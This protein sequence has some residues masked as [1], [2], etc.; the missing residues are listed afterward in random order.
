MNWV[1]MSLHRGYKRP[2]GSVGATYRMDVLCAACID[3]N[4][5]IDTLRGRYRLEIA[6]GE[7]G[8]DNVDGTFFAVRSSS[9]EPISGPLTTFVLRGSATDIADF[10]AKSR[11]SCDAAS[12]RCWSRLMTPKVKCRDPI[13]RMAFSAIVPAVSWRNLCT[14]ASRSDRED[15]VTSGIHRKCVNCGFFGG[16]SLLALFLRRCGMLL[17][18]C[19]G[20]RVCAGARK[21]ELR[22]SDAVG[23]VHLRSFRWV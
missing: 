17:R 8:L 4:D 5:L 23:T 13:G 1:R 2:D 10:S 22:D 20:N 14:L 12:S 16:P 11:R 6:G 21:R 7:I 15:S 9:L 3:S 18:G 19:D